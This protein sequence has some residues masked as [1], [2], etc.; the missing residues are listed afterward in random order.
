MGC[1]NAKIAALQEMKH[2][3]TQITVENNQ[4][5]EERDKLKSHHDDRP[6]E[7]KD[8]LQDLRTMHNDLEKEIKELKD[9]MLDFLPIPES[10]DNS[11][12]LVRT[13]IERITQ[14]QLEIEEQSEQL[15]EM[16]EKRKDLKKEHESLEQLIDSTEKEIEEI[17][18]TVEKHEWTLKEQGYFDD[19]KIKDFEKQRSLVIE[20]LRAADTT[21]KDIPGE[22]S[23][24]DDDG[25]TEKQSYENLLT[26]SE[27]EINKEIQE[28]EGELND[29]VSQIKDLDLTDVERQQMS[30]Y[31]ASLGNKLKATANMTNIKHQALEGQDKINALKAEKK[32]LKMEVEG[33]K[34]I[35]RR[36]SGDN[37]NSKIQALNDI[38]QKKNCREQVSKTVNDELVNDIE[39]TLKKARELSSSLRKK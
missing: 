37:T 31:V 38:L 19:S 17:E 34:K 23:A 22:D 36:N 18:K 16:V 2:I 15:R 6:E 10:K 11:F 13:S 9:I 32:I 7:E 30:N 28:V 26:L 24:S 29:I 33:L 20:E 39:E 8:S 4:L 21:F 35:S 27:I 25:S 12:T 3:I 5:E 14:I 1:S